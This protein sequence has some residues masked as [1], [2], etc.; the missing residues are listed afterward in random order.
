MKKDRY[1]DRRR[2]KRKGREKIEGEKEWDRRKKW[3]ELKRDGKDN[4]KW[5]TVRKVMKFQQGNQDTSRI[6]SRYYTN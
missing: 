2:R 5:C 4:E 6:S 1:R 3:K